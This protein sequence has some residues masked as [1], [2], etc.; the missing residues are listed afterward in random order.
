MDTE[1]VLYK[2]VNKNRQTERKMKKTKLITNNVL[3]VY[4]NRK[5]IEIDNLIFF[6]CMLDQQRNERALKIS[7]TKWNILRV[8]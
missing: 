3:F 1:T 7:I 2:Q 6:Y 5:T 8:E 4:N